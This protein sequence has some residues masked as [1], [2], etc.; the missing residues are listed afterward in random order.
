MSILRAISEP[1]L[2]AA[3][4]EK[5]AELLGEDKARWAQLPYEERMKELEWY[6]ANF[7]TPDDLS[8]WPAELDG[9]VDRP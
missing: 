8:P 7:N 9:G 2:S 5:L 4:F 6:H 1:V 3:Y